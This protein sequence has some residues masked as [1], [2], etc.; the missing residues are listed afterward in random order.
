MLRGMK[1]KKKRKEKDSPC[2]QI[3]GIIK[4]ER[5]SHDQRSTKIFRIRKNLKISHT[6]TILIKVYDLH[7]IGSG[8]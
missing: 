4:K 5:E 2:F 7:I 8:F 3:K 1:K 6:C